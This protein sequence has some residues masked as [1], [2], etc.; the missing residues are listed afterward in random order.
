MAWGIMHSFTLPVMELDHPAGH[1]DP[2]R[3]AR[4]EGGE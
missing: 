3:K 4:E 1:A 2:R